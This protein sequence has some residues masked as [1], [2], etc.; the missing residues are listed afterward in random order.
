[1]TTAIAP[2]RVEFLSEFDETPRTELSA[3]LRA[4]SPSTWLWC[5]HCERAFQLGAARVAAERVSCGN[6]SCEGSPLDFWSW[7]AYRAFVGA[8]PMQPEPGRCYSLA[9]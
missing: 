5:L 9:A 4:A 1:M 8:A 7:D 2:A 6:G 3:H